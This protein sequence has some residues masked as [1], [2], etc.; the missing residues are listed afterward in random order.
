MKRIEISGYATNL[1]DGIVGRLGRVEK[2]VETP[3]QDEA[4]VA[5]EHFTELRG[6]GLPQWHTMTPR[7]ELFCV[8]FGSGGHERC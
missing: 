1:V 6:F 3:V 5:D 4:N 7:E 2:P 8:Y